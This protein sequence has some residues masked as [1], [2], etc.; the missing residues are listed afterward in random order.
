MMKNIEKKT[1]SDLHT[2]RI[3]LYLIINLLIY[4]L[5]TNFNM[6]FNQYFYS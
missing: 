4:T 5:Y 2:Y 1:H 3:K 6:N